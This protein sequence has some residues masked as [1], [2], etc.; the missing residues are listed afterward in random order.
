[1]RPVFPPGDTFVWQAGRRPGSTQIT[2]IKATDLNFSGGRQFSC[3]LQ[4][5]HWLRRT[6]RE[7][8]S[9]LEEVLSLILQEQSSSLIPHPPP[10]ARVSNAARKDR[11]HDQPAAPATGQG[12]GTRRTQQP[13]R[14]VGCSSCYFGQRETSAWFCAGTSLKVHHI[15]QPRSPNTVTIKATPPF[16]QQTAQPHHHISHLSIAT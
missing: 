1:M 3:M 15:N 13:R 9:C 5:G 10:L 6:Q 7:V 16:N 2:V 4:A 8:W 12:R 11:S 14:S